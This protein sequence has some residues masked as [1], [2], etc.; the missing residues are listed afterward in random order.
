[1]ELILSG[2]PHVVNVQTVPTSIRRGAGGRRIGQRGAAA[3]VPAEGHGPRGQVRPR[4]GRSRGGIGCSRAERTKTVELTVPVRDA[5]LWTPEDPFLYELDVDTGADVYRTRF[6]MRTFTTDPATG[7]AILNGQT[8][9]LR[10][11]NVCIYRFFE[12]A[13]RGQ[14]PWDANGSASCT[15]A[16]RRCTGTASATASVSR[17][18]CGTRSPTRKAS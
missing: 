11:T 9:Y 5:R 8:Y 4:R 3:D 1:M 14:L 7:R 16:S 12:D 2:T 15:A 10:G 18:N 13:E 17:R 6:G